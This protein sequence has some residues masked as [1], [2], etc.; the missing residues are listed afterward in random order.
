MYAGAAYYNIE[1]GKRTR[2]KGKYD[3]LFAE[4]NFCADVNCGMWLFVKQQGS[5]VAFYRS[6][7]EQSCMGNSLGNSA[8]Y[9]GFLIIRI[10]AT[11]MSGVGHRMEKD[12]ENKSDT[13]GKH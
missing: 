10:C 12:D 2:A 13:G 5:T 3:L 4:K 11:I 1:T 8:L 6:L 9:W 7:S